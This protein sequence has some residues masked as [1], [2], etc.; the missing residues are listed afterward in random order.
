LYGFAKL[1]DCDR[2]AN[3]KHWLSDV[4]TGGLL[5]FGSGYY[6]VHREDEKGKKTGGFS[7][8]PSLNGL[9]FVWS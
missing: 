6:I 7:F 4:L 8:Y 3:D 1:T 9:I 5:G 2:I